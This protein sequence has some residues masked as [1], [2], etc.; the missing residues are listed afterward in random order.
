MIC[1][2][3]NN[4]AS[5]LDDLIWH[6][7]WLLQS[8]GLRYCNEE[9]PLI[10]SILILR[11]LLTHR[12]LLTKRKAYGIDGLVLK[13]IE[14]FLVGRKQ[15]VVMNNSYSNWWDVISG[16]PQGSVLS[17]ILLTIYINDLPSNLS[18]PTLLFADDN[19]IF[20]HIPRSYSSHCLQEDKLIAWSLKWQLPFNISKCKSL[21]LG[22][23]NTK[24]VYNMHGHSIE[25]VSKE[26]DLGV[27]I[28]EHL[29]F[30]EHTSYAIIADQ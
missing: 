23:F 5:S 10:L 17:P 22:R 7:W 25:E 18:N 16:V 26:K 13:W 2:L 28:D 24:H 11:K 4:M 8:N 15:R 1:L 27:I 29:K 6:N 14:A 19:K 30:H 12:Q 21:H 3:G 20:C 9:T